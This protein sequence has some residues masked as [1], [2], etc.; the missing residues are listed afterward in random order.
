MAQGKNKKAAFLQQ[1]NDILKRTQA[2]F[3]ERQRATRVVFYRASRTEHVKP[4]FE[5][6]WMNF[7]V[8][9]SG[10]M[11]DSEVRPHPS[12]CVSETVSAYPSFLV[13]QILFVSSVKAPA[14]RVNGRGV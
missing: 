9:F 10:P 13:L 12:V 6:V 4:M 1:S 11:Q 8:T 14:A 3:K 2:L 5:L 7:L